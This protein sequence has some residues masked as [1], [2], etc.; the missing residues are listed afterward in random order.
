MNRYL[1]IAL[2]ACIGSCSPNLPDHK[3]LTKD[4]D[5]KIRLDFPRM[6]SHFDH[7]F[8]TT[9]NDS[10][11]WYAITVYMIDGDS[12]NI[13]MKYQYDEKKR[14]WTFKGWQSN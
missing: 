4:I 3:Q 11:A 2:V 8:Y 7:G 12:A 14:T 1:I 5:L 6:Q 9:F 10:E 13:L